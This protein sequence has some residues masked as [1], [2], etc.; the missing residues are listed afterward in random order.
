[1]PE[2]AAAASLKAEGLSINRCL[3]PFFSFFS[4]N[5]FSRGR[6]IDGQKCLHEI[7]FTANGHAGKPFEPAV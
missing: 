2:P 6:L 7:A 1:L 5:F 3:H 4:G